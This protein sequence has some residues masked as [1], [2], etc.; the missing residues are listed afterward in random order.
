MISRFWKFTQQSLKTSIPLAYL[1]PVATQTY[2]AESS[3]VTFSCI[4]S[5]RQD[6]NAD[7]VGS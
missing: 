1:V 5:S 4:R 3:L 2:N 7:A 6:T